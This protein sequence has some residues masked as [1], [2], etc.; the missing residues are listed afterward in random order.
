M[1]R[2]HVC[3]VALAAAAL[4]PG[5]AGDANATQRRFTYTY[6]SLVLNP[7]EIEIEPWTTFRIGKE[8]YYVRIDHRIEFEA[9]LTRSLQTAFYLNMKSETAQV[10]DEMQTGFEWQ[11]ISN[12]WKLKLR[13]PVADPFGMA[14][15]FEWGASTD[16]VEVEAKFIADKRAGNWLWAFNAMI[17]PEFE[18]EAETGGDVEAETELNYEFNLGGA[19]FLTPNT[20]LGIE[21][22]N[23]N[24]SI[25][26]TD[27][28][29]SA[30]FA[31]P[32]VSYSAE[33]W[34]ATLTVLP[35]VAKLK[36]DEVDE[37]NDL[38]LSELEKVEVRFLF[39]FDL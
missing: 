31:G 18:F 27:Y 25:S 38:V 30:L 4:A 36:G 35:Q 26:E 22:R 16:E 1:H 11:G 5:F 14:L 32:V 10:G 6:E 33:T 15:Y 29:H 37:G 12:E 24:L 13:D 39:G 21:V 9:G 34:W 19:Y 2:G 17:E 23:H 20:S 28:S 3:A 8:D 7:G